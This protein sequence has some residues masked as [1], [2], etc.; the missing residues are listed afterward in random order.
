MMDGTG[1]S[2]P[3]SY[4]P[5]GL[6]LTANNNGKIIASRAYFRP[7]APPAAGDENPCPGENGTSHGMSVT[8]EASHTYLCSGTATYTVRVEIP[9]AMLS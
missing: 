2:Y 6:G 4:G 1:Y 3:A 9:M 5:N 8:S 7:W